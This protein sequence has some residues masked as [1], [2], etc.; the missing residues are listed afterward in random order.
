MW[1]LPPP[2]LR[3]VGFSLLTQM[4]TNIG[5]LRKKVCLQDI[6]WL[7]A[8]SKGSPE[9]VAKLYQMDLHV[10]QSSGRLTDRAPSSNDGKY[11]QLRNVVYSNTPGDGAAAVADRVADIA[12]SLHLASESAK[13]MAELTYEANKA[14]ANMTDE[15]RATWASTSY[16][17]SRAR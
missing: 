6:D 11:D 4:R 9:A 17:R 13:F 1:T 15:Q 2:R 10:Q 16:S 14:T 12:A 7:A 3:P 8:Y 5:K